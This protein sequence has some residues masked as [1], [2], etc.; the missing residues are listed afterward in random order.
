MTQQ[1]IVA[2]NKLQRKYFCD[3]NF[4]DTQTEDMA[5][6]LGFLAA[7]GT[8]SK[9]SNQIKI[10]VAQ[11]DSNLLEEIKKRLNYTGVVKYTTTNQNFDIATLEVTCEH[12]KKTLAEYNIVPNKTF[13]FSIPEKLDKKY[14]R[15]FIRGYFDG[16]GSVST[17]GKAAFR[18]Q[19]CSARKITLQQILTYLEE[20][21]HI[22]ATRIYVAPRAQH[23]LYYFQ[24]STNATRLLYQALYYDNC[25]CLQRKR[26]KFEKLI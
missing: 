17:A 14:W 25:L 10:T 2:R 5:Y 22:P 6:I 3:E 4:F 21:Y 26:A 20:F 15:D 9:N 24:Y 13:T 12:Y 23:P 1:E 11:K 16:D 19:I 7:D 8:V 18:S